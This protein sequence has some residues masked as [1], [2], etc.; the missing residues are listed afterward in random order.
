MHAVEPEMKTIC[1]PTQH[2]SCVLAWATY[3]SLERT[4]HNSYDR[5]LA[6]D[7]RLPTTDQRPPTTDHRPP[8]ADCRLLT[9]DYRP[10]TTSYSTDRRVPISDYQLPITDIFF[11]ASRIKRNERRKTEENIDLISPGLP[12][13]CSARLHNARPPARPGSA[14]PGC[15]PDDPVQQGCG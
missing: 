12:R 8:I 1:Q 5:L 13:S 9:V 6:A 11:R 4:E 14:S 7:Y 15:P 3:E 2:S 10:L